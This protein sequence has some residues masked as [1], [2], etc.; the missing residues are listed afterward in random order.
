M[1]IVNVKQIIIRY[2]HFLY[3]FNS[4]SLSQPWECKDPNAKGLINTVFNEWA[5][6]GSLSCVDAELR[7]N[8]TK[9]ED[10]K[11]QGTSV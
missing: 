1:E 6:Q 10:E 4:N 2:L 8:K 11:I 7:N 9:L 3:V 5:K